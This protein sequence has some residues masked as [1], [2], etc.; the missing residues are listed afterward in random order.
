MQIH[1]IRAY[2]I[3]L[4]LMLICRAFTHKRYRQQHLNQFTVAPWVFYASGIISLGLSFGLYARPI[5]DVDIS[6]FVLFVS[7]CLTCT[8]I[9]YLQIVWKIEYNEE[10]LLF[11]NFFGIVRKYPIQGLSII[12]GERIN[13]L[14]YND[15]KI[16]EWD[17]LIMDIEADVRM[18]RFITQ[19]NMKNLPPKKRKKLPKSKR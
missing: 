10:E 18:A 3:F 4:V 2:Q 13:K 15:K 1:I 14:M 19:Q 9:M 16:A 8:I 11:R 7:A 5:I 17:F 12:E 6:I